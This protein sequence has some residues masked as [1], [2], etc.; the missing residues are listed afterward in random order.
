MASAMMFELWEKKEVERCSKVKGGKK[1]KKKIKRK[2]N[3]GAIFTL[4]SSL[5]LFNLLLV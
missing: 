1:K 3:A 5:Y 4:S 2:K